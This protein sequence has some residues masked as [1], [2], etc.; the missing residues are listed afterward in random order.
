[1][2]VYTDRLQQHGRANRDTQTSK[3]MD[4]VTAQ[5]MAGFPDSS[6]GYSLR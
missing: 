3:Q 1:M 5:A 2:L 4:E 6:A